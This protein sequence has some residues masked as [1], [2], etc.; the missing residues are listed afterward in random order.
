M[1]IRGPEVQRT[2]HTL[3]LEKT[4]T[5]AARQMLRLA[6][7]LNQLIRESQCNERICLRKRSSTKA[8]SG[9]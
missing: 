8:F 2:L 7:I 1:P 3:C 5:L 9:P 6:P 4:E